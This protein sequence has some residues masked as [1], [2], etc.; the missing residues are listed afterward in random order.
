[1]TR[2]IALACACLLSLASLASACEPEPRELVAERQAQVAARMQEEQLLMAR[3]CLARAS[4]LVPAS[5]HLVDPTRAALWQAAGRAAIETPRAAEIMV[6]RAEEEALRADL[7]RQERQGRREYRELCCGTHDC[8]PDGGRRKGLAALL[9]GGLL[10][11]AIAVG[12][13]LARLR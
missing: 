12:A 5:L 3:E 10:A 1:M 7:E 11:S 6:L 9:I 8:V 4:A 13:V 2:T